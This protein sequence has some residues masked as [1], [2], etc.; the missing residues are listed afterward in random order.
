MN[1]HE[2]EEEANGTERKSKGCVNERKRKKEKS[3]STVQYD[4]GFGG[5]E[6]FSSQFKIK[7]TIE[8]NSISNQNDKV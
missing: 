8:A 3:G 7:D 6:T 5:I 1:G 2:E 4:L